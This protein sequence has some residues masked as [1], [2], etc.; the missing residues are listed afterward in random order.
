[1][2]WPTIS[3][4]VLRL[5]LM[6]PAP[7]TKEIPVWCRGRCALWPVSLSSRKA[8]VSKLLSNLSYS[9]WRMCAQS[10]RDSVSKLWFWK[11]VWRM[12]GVVATTPSFNK[13][14][15]FW[16]R[17]RAANTASW[18]GCYLGYVRNSCKRRCL[19]IVACSLQALL[20]TERGLP[21]H[22]AQKVCE[23]VRA[24]RLSSAIMMQR[25][26]CFAGVIENFKT[27]CPYLN[28]PNMKSFWVEFEAIIQTGI[29]FMCESKER[30]FKQNYLI[31][32]N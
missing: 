29:P 23:S 25:N 3:C 8:N 2:D 27:M 13:V 11:K 30:F 7:S 32:V 18:T 19:D 15:Y 17:A 26:V 21:V 6:V 16:W 28:I 10:L 14:Q 9:V 5:K 4:P 24:F 20:M 22:I 31:D 12:R 1:M